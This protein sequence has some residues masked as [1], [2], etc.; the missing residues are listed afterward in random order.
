MH[1]EKGQKG[2]FDVSEQKIKKNCIRTSR[3]KGDPGIDTRVLA[4]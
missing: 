4:K 1:Y 3:I 2:R